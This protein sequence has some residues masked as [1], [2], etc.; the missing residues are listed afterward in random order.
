VEEGSRTIILLLGIIIVMTVVCDDGVVCHDYCCCLSMVLLVRCLLYSVQRI[1]ITAAVI[2]DM[3][4]DIS[5][6]KLA[7]SFFQRH[8]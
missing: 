2:D 7:C 8:F 4:K 5:T 1:T 6:Y 3:S